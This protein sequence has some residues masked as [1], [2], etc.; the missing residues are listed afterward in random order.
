MWLRGLFLVPVLALAFGAR[1]ALSAEGNPPPPPPPPA[2]PKPEDLNRLPWNRGGPPG[3]GG[4][5]G[6]GFGGGPMKGGQ[7][8]EGLTEDE[9]KRLRGAVEKVWGNAEVA[10]AR[11]KIM[12]ANEEL[13]ATLREALKKTDPEVVAILEKVKTSPLAWDQHRGPP[14]PRPEDPDFPAQ[15]TARLGFE[16]MSF[17]RPEQR[18]AFRHLHDRVVE[19]PAVKEA[20]TKL[21]AAPHE[22]RIEAFKN[23]KDVYKRECEQAIETFRR[24]HAGEGAKEGNLAAPKP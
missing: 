2:P 6:H 11:E 8:M 10:A 4:M 17:A 24:R 3:Q 14:L 1:V 12:K 23:L 9:K 7:G 13:R 16:M 18:E 22:G 15:A 5:P 19:L 20:I 21:K